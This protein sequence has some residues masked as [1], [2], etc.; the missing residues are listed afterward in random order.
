MF[1]DDDFLLTTRTARTLFHEY[2]ESL[3][4]IDYHCHLN[5]SE[6][7]GDENFSGITEAWLGGDDYGDHY[8]WRLM[9]ANG[10]PEELV[11]GATD[12]W[13]KF[14]AFATTMEKA[15]GNPVHLWTHLELK[16]IF[17]IDDLLTSATA[18]SIYDRANELLATPEFSRRN[19]IRRFNV[20]VVCTTDDPA[21]DL[22]FHRELAESETAFR[23]IPAFRPDKALNVDRAGYGEWLGRLEDA[24]GH[25]ISG[26]EGLAGA[27]A[28]RIG[29]FD[30]LGG[31]LSD[32]AI[33][34]MT[35]DEA[36]P[37]ELD[38]IVERA[39][40]GVGVKLN[41]REVSQ[42]RT[43]VIKALMRANRDHDWTMQLHIHAS[44][45]L[46][47]AELARHGADTGFDGLSDGPLVDPLVKLLDSMA[48]DDSLP[49]MILYSLNPNDW[50][51][52]AAAFGCF[53]G[54]TVQRF[55]LGNAWW[56]ND[57]RSGIR[58]QL[59]TM[60]EQSLLGNFVGMTTDSRSFLS[61]PRHEFFRRILCELVGEWAERGEITNDIEVLGDLV[62]N[63]SHDNAEKFFAF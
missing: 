28:E 23:V 13:E 62:R 52:M 37:A 46:N 41:P 5:P 58:R 15:I 7:A 30:S 12:P 63:V 38:S 34:E 36:T 27:L 3:P 35:Y 57:T 2:A 32:H 54:G 55:Q 22:H 31:R 56:F 53:Q 1:L 60:A 26:F 19:L 14:Q 24:V 47:S 61:Y 43:E 10:V 11:T 45:D 42:Y 49:R 33:D 25:S 51:A 21:D 17:G 8:K 44:R 9:R 18:R 20:E 4:I 29:Y 39:R 6:I 16:R 59:E 40:S 48:S 50:L